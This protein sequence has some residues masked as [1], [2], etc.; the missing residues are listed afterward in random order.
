MKAQASANYLNSKKT[1]RRQYEGDSY[2]DEL[3]VGMKEDNE[4]KWK[5]SSG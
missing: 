3:A 1:E 2:R 5:M 4:G